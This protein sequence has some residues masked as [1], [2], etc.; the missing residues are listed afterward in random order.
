MVTAARVV[1]VVLALVV[2]AGCSRASEG[3]RI[4]VAQLDNEL[5]TVIHNEL[6]AQGFDYA[7]RVGCVPSGGS[8][9]QFSCRVDATNPLRPTQSWTETVSCQPPKASRAQACAS[10][11][12]DALQ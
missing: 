8:D 1:G 7:V 3:N 11:R 10:S 4:D 12:G 6:L 2:L 9:L 5:A